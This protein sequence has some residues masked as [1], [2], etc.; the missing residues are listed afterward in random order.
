MDESNGYHPT[1]TVAVQ[2]R[3]EPDL[4]AWI[5]RERTQRDT[6][7]NLFILRVLRLYRAD[8]EARLLSEPSTP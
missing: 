3:M 7:L 4:R 1:A 2:I 6:S 8:T 5:E